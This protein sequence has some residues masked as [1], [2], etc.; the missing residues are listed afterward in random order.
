[1]SEKSPASA[2]AGKMAKQLRKSISIDVKMQVIR[3]VEASE[4]QVDVGRSLGLN[5]ST[6]R[7]IVKNADKIRTSAQSTTSLTATKTTRSRSILPEKMEGR[8]SLVQQ[9]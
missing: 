1:M 2:H 3:L 9:F 8:L 5:T 4:C 6:I 7:T